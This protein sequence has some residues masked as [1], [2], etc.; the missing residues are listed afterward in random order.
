MR[1]HNTLNIG[2]GEAGGSPLDNDVHMEHHEELLD[3]SSRLQHMKDNLI[4]M[5]RGSGFANKS[6]DL[7]RQIALLKS[8]ECIKE[9]EVREL[10][11]MARDI[12]LEESNIQNINSPITV[13]L[14]SVYLTH[15]FIYRFVET[16]MASSTI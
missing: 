9:S 1:P 14:N 5:N 15:I 7:D 10:C 4:T 11:N 6:A 3:Q 2:E 13:S 16:S 8:C 12:L